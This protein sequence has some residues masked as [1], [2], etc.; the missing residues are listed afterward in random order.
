MH[1]NN[2]QNNTYINLIENVF[3]MF[4]II[5]IIGLILY[6]RLI[7]KISKD[8]VKNDEILK[9]SEISEICEMAT[10]RCYYHNVAEFEKQP[11][12]MFKHGLFKYG[13]KKIWIEYSG[14]VE[15]GIEAGDVKISTPDESGNIKIY[16]PEAKIFNVTADQDSL[17]ETLSETGMF[18]EI[19]VEDK[20]QAFSEAQQNM[21][22]EAETDKTIL[23]QARS[24]AK[25]LIKQYVTS[26]GEITGYQ[27]NIIWE[28]KAEENKL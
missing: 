9:S 12:D 22:I 19:S 24:N 27:Y 14:I 4:L 23:T 13:Y 26:I 11:D 5:I 20:A 10:L 1:A 7:P 6:V 25:E 2:N 21:R 28:E 16:I 15:V 3:I 8:T 18:T 17:V